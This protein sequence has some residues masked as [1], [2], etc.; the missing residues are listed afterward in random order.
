MA[1]AKITALTELTTPT[2]SDLLAIV[3]DPSGSPVT[4]KI[5]LSKFYTLFQAFQVTAT[6]G[7]TTTNTDFEDMTNG[8]Q[9]VTLAV[10]SHVF[11]QCQGNFASSTSMV[12]YTQATY[13][14][15]GADTVVGD[16]GYFTYG[17]AVDSYNI[18]TGGVVTSLAAGT[19]TF[20]YQWKVNTGTGTAYDPLMSILVIPAGS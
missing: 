1:D 14:S 11:V 8:T 13:D 3:D 16:Q 7:Q 4:K 15:G 20:A 2:L 18:A 9:S 19:Y 10:A 12:I 5:A 17:G 6:Q